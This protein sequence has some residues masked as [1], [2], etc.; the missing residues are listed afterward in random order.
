MPVATRVT[1]KRGWAAACGLRQA[2]WNARLVGVLLV[3]FGMAGLYVVLVEGLHPA[4]GGL[5]V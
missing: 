4:E 1:D 3:L 5:G 2:R